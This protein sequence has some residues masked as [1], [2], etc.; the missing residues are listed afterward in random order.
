MAGRTVGP[1]CHAIL[2]LCTGRLSPTYG[3]QASASPP[4][5]GCCLLEAPSK[6]SPPSAMGHHW[7]KSSFWHWTYGLT[8]ES[9]LSLIPALSAFM[10]LLLSAKAIATRMVVSTCGNAIEAAKAVCPGR[11][12][13][14]FAWFFLV[15][16]A[17]LSTFAVASTVLQP[18][19]T[20]PRLL[21]Q[22]A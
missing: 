4:A 8:L 17:E 18:L 2:A 15:V 14:A 20:L 13:A 10:G 22:A 16:L 12:K 3:G 19:L 1:H 6:H 21:L 7:L 11:M 9:T 5:W